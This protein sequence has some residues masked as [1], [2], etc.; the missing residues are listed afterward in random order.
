MM[1]RAAPR[2]VAEE[3][4]NFLARSWRW[5][6]IKP[7]SPTAAAVREAPPMENWWQESLP[8]HLGQLP[9]IRAVTLSPWAWPFSA[10]GARP[11]GCGAAENRRDFAPSHAING[12]QRLKET[13][14]APV[15]QRKE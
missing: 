9:W 6:R 3:R 5:R 2:V 4:L 15:E 8:L 13:D 10:R 14:D 12:R 11:T 1:A 7:L